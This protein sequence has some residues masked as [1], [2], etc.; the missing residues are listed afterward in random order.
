[1]KRKIL[2]MIAVILLMSTM[3]GTFASC[4][5]ID[6]I[7]GKDKNNDESNEVPKAD[8]VVFENGKYSSAFVY[9]IMA[10]A[11]ESELRSK[12]RSAFKAKMGLS[13]NFLGDD[14]SEANAEVVEILLGNTNRPES[15]A[16][17]GVVEG[18]DSYYTVAVIGNK[19]VINGSDS[20]HLGLAVQYFI[21][22]YLSGDAAESLTIP[23]TLSKQEILKDFTREL[24]GLEGEGIPAYPVGVNTLVSSVYSCGTTI[25]GLSGNSNKS[26]TS[27]QR[28]DKTNMEEFEDYLTKLESFGF[29]KEYENL[30][31]ENLFLTY[32]NGDRRVHVS[33]RPNIKEVQVISEPKGLNVDE[34]GYSYT[35][36]AGE[37]SEY[38]L[39][40][41][42]MNDGKGNNHPNCGTLS[43]IKCADNSVIVI[44]GGAYEGDGGIQMYTKEVMDAFD[45]FLH[46]ITKTPDGEKVRISCWYLTHYHADHVYGFLEFLKAYN[47]NYELER[48]V[49]NLPT[50]NC[51][52]TA[53]P[54]PE[55]VTNWAYRMLE[56][57]NYLLKS[58]YPNCK[59]IKVHAGQ[60]I[61]IADVTLDVL[62]T[63]EDLLS[64]KGRFSSSDS[65]DTSTV[66]RVD[67]KQMSMMI[68]G[69]AS[70]ATEAKIR[71]MYTEVSLKSDIV[72][73]AHHLIYA[74]FDI[75]KEIQ[76]TY[77]LVTQATEL[78]QSNSTLPGQGSY[79]DRYNKLISLVDRENCYFA[80]NETVGLAVVNGKIE[81]I[82]HVEG[83]VGREEGKG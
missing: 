17:A 72:Q 28:V 45:A 55:E 20:Y 14:K 19:I 66:I 23:H 7:T 13:P 16:P 15:A 82:Y 42:P 26:D 38:Y 41:L 12:L 29:E 6:K 56:Q 74:V 46:Q 62:Y 78:M 36:K 33:F 60:K 11:S 1:M 50:A 67:N 81:V 35:P 4:D 69:D 24:W 49:A 68:L 83:V 37:R 58:T 18:S 79:K 3:I 2:R 22:T 5:L 51:G 64:N 43:V 71:R 39:Y 8:L 57:W 61:Q 80:G 25:S 52:G 48:I 34:F 47:A 31:E 70:L 40:G 75:Y 53:N 77:A 32:R 9:S 30:T 27:L 54:F 76:P 44:D 10:D 63:H 21:E 59:E 65:N 73:P